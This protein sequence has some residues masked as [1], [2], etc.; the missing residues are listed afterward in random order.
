[1]T[2]LKLPAKQTSHNLWNG[3]NDPGTTHRGEDYGWR[4]GPEVLSAA[5]GTVVSVF[6]TGYNQGWGL[7]VRIKHAENVYTTYNHLEPGS[8]RVKVGDKV[9]S[10]VTIALMGAT[11]FAPNGKHLHFELEIGGAGGGFRVNPRP[12]F[13][14]HLPGTEPSKPTTGS[15]SNLKANQRVVRK[16][17]SE[18]WLNGRSDA[19]TK[20]AVRQ[21][22]EPGTVANFDAWKEGQRVTID[23]V[24]SNIWLRGAFKKNWFAAAG[25]TS[26]STAGLKKITTI[27]PPKQTK[28]DYFKTP[29]N[30]TQF[31]FRQFN[32]A[33]NGTNWSR[34]RM[35]PAGGK[36]PYRVLEN[37]RK[38]PIRI[39]VPGVGNVWVGTKNHPA[40]I[41]KI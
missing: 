1:M 13:S 7:R 16:L 25:L 10:G 37:S 9:K 17:G 36:I 18:S 34:Q 26:R 27:L 15:P 24:T 21:R 2:I 41:V 8:I 40:K 3:P 4:S 22:L 35:L 32:D 29:K 14:K 12:Y 11:G 33:Y 31:Y 20:A 6:T 5:E 38:G 23:G 30:N 19:T 39:S 28:K